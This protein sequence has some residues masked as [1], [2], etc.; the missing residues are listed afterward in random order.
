M[1]GSIEMILPDNDAESNPTTRHQYGTCVDKPAGGHR[2][3][4]SPISAIGSCRS[5]SSVGP[6]WIELL[7]ASGH[8]DIIFPGLPHCSMASSRLLLYRHGP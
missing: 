7:T 4:V 2:Q 8:P 3:S 5:N 1:A 6:D